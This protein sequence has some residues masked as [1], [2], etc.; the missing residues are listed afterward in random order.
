MTLI[1][2][3]KSWIEH[4]PPAGKIQAGLVGWSGE[5]GFVCAVCA[6]RIVGRGCRLTTLAKN[7]V[8][9]LKPCKCAL[10]EN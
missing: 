7:P 2:L 6:S 8:W 5:V 1:E 3:G 9:D 4:A 10:C